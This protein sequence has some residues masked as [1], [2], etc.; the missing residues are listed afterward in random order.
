MPKRA[1]RLLLMIVT[2]GL[3]L[4][5]L[6]AT[7]TAAD[8]PFSNRFAKT[9]RG[10][11][12]VFG[13][14]SLSCPDANANCANARSRTLPAGQ[15][16]NDY[17]MTNVDVD[18]DG[19]TFNSSSATLALPAG[20]AVE[21]A[22]L[23]WAADTSAASGGAAA[24]DA[25]KK[26]QVRVA[27]DGGAYQ[28]VTAAAADVLTSSLQANRTAR[29]PTSRACSPPPAAPPSPSPTCRPAPGQD[30]FGGWSLLVA[31]RNSALP[32]WRLDA[33]DGLGTV[34]PSQSF[35]T[36]IGPL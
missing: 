8:T 10:D 13:N 3:G 11:I 5:A 1:V 6:S 2:T 26:A 34:N 24:P 28:T 15:S 27:I 35:S 16:D 36:T 4:G 20:S 14:A 32:I 17:S 9:V 21:W 19:T 31:Y 12:A 25:T 22:G 29:S 30:R 7:A 33:Y 18:S 23:Y